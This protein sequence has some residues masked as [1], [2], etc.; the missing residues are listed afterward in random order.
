M[1]CLSDEVLESDNLYSLGLLQVSVEPATDV[2]AAQR[3]S[4]ATEHEVGFLVNT[5]FERLR[6]EMIS[7]G[8]FC[9]AVPETCCHFR[10]SKKC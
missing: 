5:I 7:N 1:I 3:P 2:E 4:L 10:D 8:T 6:R 9:S